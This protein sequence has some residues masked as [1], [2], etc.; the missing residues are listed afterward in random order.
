MTLVG[1]RSNRAAAFSQGQGG[2]GKAVTAEG[3][4]THARA[5]EHRSRGPSS[6][7]AGAPRLGLRPRT[8]RQAGVPGRRGGE[9]APRPW[10]GPLPAHPQE[11]SHRKRWPLC[12]F[13]CFCS[14]SLFNLHLG[15]PSARE[16]WCCDANSQG[17]Q[18]RWFCTVQDFL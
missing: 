4:W 7:A 17:A 10:A 1:A 12:S 9:R 2:V 5:Q 15:T 18:K 13:I 3:K 11:A 14:Y 8:C 6:G 16:H